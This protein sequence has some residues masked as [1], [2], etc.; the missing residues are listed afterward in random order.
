[1]N[2]RN[3]Y[4]VNAAN[5][6]ASRRSLPAGA[7]GPSCAADVITTTLSASLSVNKAWAAIIPPSRDPRLAL[8]RCFV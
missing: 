3:E 6:D 5:V 1:M 2:R 4:I 7:V 8:A